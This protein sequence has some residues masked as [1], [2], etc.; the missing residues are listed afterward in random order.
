MST[1]IITKEMKPAGRVGLRRWVKY[2]A[3]NPALIKTVKEPEL[4]LHASRSK[5]NV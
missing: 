3:R 1:K 2:I 4:Y 5:A